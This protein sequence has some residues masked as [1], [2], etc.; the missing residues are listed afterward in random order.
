MKKS[1]CVVGMGVL[2]AGYAVGVGTST[3]IGA[4]CPNPLGGL[5]L[6]FFLG[7]IA[8]LVLV[9]LGAVILLVSD[10]GR[11][12]GDWVLWAVINAVYCGAVIFLIALFANNVSPYFGH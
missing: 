4:A 8:G 9:A 11:S 10:R 1:G 6:G 3:I 2:A 12:I 7:G 5:G